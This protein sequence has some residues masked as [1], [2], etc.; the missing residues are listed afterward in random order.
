MKSRSRK[1]RGGKVCKGHKK[2]RVGSPRQRSFCARMCGHRR[3]N[4][5]RKT[6]RD[7]NSCIN[8]SLRRWKCRCASL[9]GGHNLLPEIQRHVEV[10]SQS[11]KGGQLCE[12]VEYVA[13]YAILI[14]V[15][16]AYNAGLGPSIFLRLADNVLQLDFMQVLIF[17]IQKFS[18]QQWKQWIV[19]LFNFLY[20]CLGGETTET[21]FSEIATSP[22]TIVAFKS[23]LMLKAFDKVATYICYV[24]TAIKRLAVAGAN[25]AQVTAQFGK[26]LINA[27]KEKSD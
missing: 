19:M 2:D 15:V 18:L 8:Q 3:V 27:V 17:K 22:Q 5:S 9:K 13:A 26:F 7:P 1:M 25:A 16:L 21:T 4:T 14:A 10:E 24:L 23:L 6:A 12:T 11:L 20:G